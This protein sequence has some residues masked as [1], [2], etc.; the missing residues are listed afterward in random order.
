MNAVMLAKSQ[1]NGAKYEILDQ[2]GLGL[3]ELE[4]D[5]F[6]PSPIPDKNY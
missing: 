5:G 3:S 2:L 4:L 6:S 1:Y